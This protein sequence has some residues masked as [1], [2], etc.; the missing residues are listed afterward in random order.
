[1]TQPRS[2]IDVPKL[3]VQA[4]LPDDTVAATLAIDGIMMEWRRRA[5][6]RE[7]ASI[8]LRTLGIGLELPQFDVLLA[9]EG[10]IGGNVADEVTVGLVADRLGIDPSRASRLVGEMVTRGYAR[11]TVSQAD[12][13]RAILALT[14]RGATVV[15]AVRA[16]KFIAMGDFFAGWSAEDLERLT[17]LLPRLGQWLDRVEAA[18]QAHGA[19]V[20]HLARIVAAAEIDPQAAKDA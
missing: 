13:R 6:R 14:R 11:R 18:G 15:Q 16:Y 10:S 3:L 20:E 2:H 5:G 4:G 17:T 1:M 12:A 9:I 8:A 19:E 7:V